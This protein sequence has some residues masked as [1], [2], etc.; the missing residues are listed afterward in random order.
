[1]TALFLLLFH[2]LLSFRRIGADSNLFTDNG[3]V[4]SFLLPNDQ[5]TLAGNDLVPGTGYDLLANYDLDPGSNSDLFSS[6]SSDTGMQSILRARDGK[7]VCPPDSSTPL[8]I[9]TFPTLDQ[10]ENAVQ[11]PSNPPPNRPE[12]KRP[13]GPYLYLPK[14][15]QGQELHGDQPEYYC[16]LYVTSYTPPVPHQIPVCGTVDPS[17]R[18]SRGG[19]EYYAVHHAQLRQLHLRQPASYARI[20]NG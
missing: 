18:S 15:D 12:K 4:S 2:F 5:E 11:G 6:C 10:I 1:M 14:D 13:H 19:F 9:P 7:T 3:D 20:V 8:V 16:N 17:E